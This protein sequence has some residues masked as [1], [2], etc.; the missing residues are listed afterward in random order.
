MTI[1]DKK[2][3]GQKGEAIQLVTDAAGRLFEHWNYRPVV[4]RVWALLVLSSSPLD[5]EQI[6]DALGISTGATSMSLKALQDLD[7]IYRELHDGKRRF[8]YFAELDYW[9][10]ATRIY[11]ERERKRFSDALAGSRTGFV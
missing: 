11:R 5:A 4:G 6:Q 2:V 10:I 3:T 9:V 7:L 8:Y 1:K